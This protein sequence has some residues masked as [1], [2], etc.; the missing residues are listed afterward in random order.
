M[1][2]V[3]CCSGEARESGEVSAPLNYFLREDY[4]DERMGMPRDLNGDSL[5]DELDHADDYTVLP[6]HVEIEWR[7]TFGP[8]RLDLYT[9]IALLSKEP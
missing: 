7:G 6:V 5:I 9:Q 2:L 1:W 8:R 3:K 4:V